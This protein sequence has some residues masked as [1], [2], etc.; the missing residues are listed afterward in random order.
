MGGLSVAGGKGATT[1]LKKGHDLLGV[2]GVEGGVASQSLVHAAAVVDRIGGGGRWQE[3][4]GCDNTHAKE[5]QAIT[6]IRSQVFLSCNDGVFPPP[7]TSPPP[8][9][10]LPREIK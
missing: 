3:E 6:A 2:A 7:P 5:N 1:T 4:G 9:Y 10:L 8:P